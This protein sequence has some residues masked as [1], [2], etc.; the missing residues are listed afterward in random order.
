MLP[1]RPCSIITRAACLVPAKTLRTRTANVR[2]QSSTLISVS[3]P[4]A[5]PTPALLNSTSR[6]PNV[7]TAAWISASTSASSATSVRM[8]QSRSGSPTSSTSALAVLGVVVADD[9]L[10]ALV[11]EAQHRRLA[12][13]AGPSGDDG[14][15]V[16]EHIRHGG[17]ATRGDL[18]AG[19]RTGPG[20]EGP[21]RQASRRPGRRV[22]ARR[23]GPGGRHREA[24]GEATLG[25]GR[26]S[27][28]WRTGERRPFTRLAGRDPGGREPLGVTRPR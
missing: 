28:G 20:E 1:P 9:D 5:P 26:R 17:E 16:G 23:G 19:H 10:G 7:S 25:D 18:P 6:P 13:A 15:A 24:A 12:D 27:V 22:S 14:D 4:N 8:K 21:V 3:G 11:E 2:S